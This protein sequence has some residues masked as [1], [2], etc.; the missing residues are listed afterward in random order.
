MAACG[1]RQA[2]A[3]KRAYSRAACPLA[4]ETETE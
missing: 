3:R 1:S 2:L 4:I